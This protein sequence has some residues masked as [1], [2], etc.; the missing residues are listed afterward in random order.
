VTVAVRAAAP[1]DF[2]TLRAIERAAGR[3]FVDIGMEDI[4]ADEPPSVEVLS[5][6][7]DRGMAWVLADADDAPVGYVIVD[8]VDGCAHVEQISVHPDQQRK[9]HGRT[10]IDHVADWARSQSMAA[11]TL[12]TFREVP[13]NAPYYERLGFRPLAEAELGPELAAVRANEAAHGL[14]PTTRVCMRRDL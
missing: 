6:Y 5:G 9:G 10:L 11:L 2:E 3:L 1:R 13:W 14:D 7:A 8:I 12:T 4:A